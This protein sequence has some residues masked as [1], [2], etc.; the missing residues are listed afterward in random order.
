[1]VVNI[2]TRM[3]IVVCPVIS[4]VAP[5]KS[6]G[7]DDHHEKIRSDRSQ[8]LEGSQSMIPQH[9][10][11]VDPHIVIILFKIDPE[12][13]QALVDTIAEE[14]TE[15]V[16][17]LSGFLSATFHTSTDGTRVVNHAQWRSKEA[18]KAFINDPRN[19]RIRERIDD[20]DGVEV[21]EIDMNH[22]SVD[23]VFMAADGSDSVE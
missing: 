12:K 3:S 11:T 14:M 19:D 15:W 17:G 10:E 8:E 21:E 23:R 16:R 4:F 2:F 9:S 22:Y 20:V 13:Q 18:W 7:N 6:H 5:T 1:M